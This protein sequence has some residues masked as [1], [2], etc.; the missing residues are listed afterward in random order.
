MA[1]R[2]LLADRQSQPA[3]VQTSKVNPFAI[4]QPGNFGEMIRTGL[5]PT[6][7][8]TSD[9]GL[10][11]TISG[12]SG[13]IEFAST[14]HAYHTVETLPTETTAPASPTVVAKGMVV[15]FDQASFAGKEALTLNA[16]DTLTVSDVVRIGKSN[17]IGGI[18]TGG[19]KVFVPNAKVPNMRRLEDARRQVADV[20][21]SGNEILAPADLTAL[22]HSIQSIGAEKVVGVSVRLQPPLD[23]AKRYSEASSQ[24]RLTKIRAAL[25]QLGVQSEVI[26]E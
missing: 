19:K 14:Q 21:F 2:K 26:G 1:A 12:L 13:T 18:T 22:R 9:S 3:K 24:L 4:E 16:G 17:W 20:T 23:V 25:I 8:A 11:N 5:F 10:V 15:A 7:T 6:N